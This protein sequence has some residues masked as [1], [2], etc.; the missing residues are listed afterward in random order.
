MPA[1][2]HRAASARWVPFAL[3][4]LGLIPL[5]TGS[6]RLGELLGGPHLMPDNPRINAFPLPVVVHLASVIP[7]ALLGAFQFSA[8]LRRRHPVWHRLAGRAL[9]VLGLAVALSGLWMTLGYPRQTGTGALLYVVRLGVGSAMAVSIALGL[10]AVRRRDIAHHRAWMTRAYAL[11]LGAGT[12]ALTGAVVVP[13]LGTGVLATDLS[14]TAGWAIN[15]AV[16]EFVIRRGRLRARR[17]PAR[18][19]AA[20]GRAT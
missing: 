11:A 13:L 9:V 15:L 18:V 17:A 16:A 2:T 6:V 10:A 8:G 14:M 4:A 19:E 3:L 12:Q 1:S 20:Q 7:Y 5:I